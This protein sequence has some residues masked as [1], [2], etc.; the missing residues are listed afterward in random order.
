VAEAKTNN[1]GGTLKVTLI[2]SPIGNPKVQ[3]ATVK[4]L[5]LN[6]LHQTVE[7][8]DNPAVRGQIYKVRHLLQV[9]EA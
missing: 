2:N 7:L 4:A 9:E 5:G 1:A 8:P 6:R 3:K